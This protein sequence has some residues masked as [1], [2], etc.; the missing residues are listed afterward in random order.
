M[1]N[2]FLNA[3][4][5]A[6]L[7]VQFFFSP[8]DLLD[9]FYD[10][11]F[12]AQEKRHSV[13]R[14]RYIQFFYF[15]K[16]IKHVTLYFMFDNSNIQCLVRSY[17]AV[18]CLCNSLSWYLTTLSAS[19]FLA[20]SPYSLNSYLRKFLEVEIKLGFSKPWSIGPSLKFGHPLRI[21]G[22]QTAGF[23][24]SFSIAFWGDLHVRKFI[25]LSLM[26]KLL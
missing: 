17:F 25:C 19:L 21:S 10:L 12:F 18:C 14:R 6:F 15:C 20:V 26:F 9:L 22:S 16:T 23:T 1:F 2:L 7:E 11:L 13:S 4:S 24:F 8:S 3:F 5:I